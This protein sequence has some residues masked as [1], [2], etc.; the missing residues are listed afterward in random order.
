MGSVGFACVRTGGK[1][2][3]C[4]FERNDRLARE[5]HE[6]RWLRKTRSRF[7]ASF[8]SDERYSVAGVRNGSH[9]VLNVGVSVISQICAA[10]FLA[11]ARAG[12][13][14]GTALFT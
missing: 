10:S 14:F 9:S 8:G 4:A 2:D 7:E 13:P 1:R 3:P 11:R 5:T 6:C 12:L